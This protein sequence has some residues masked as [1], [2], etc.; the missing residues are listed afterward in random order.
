MCFEM[1][2][3]LGTSIGTC[4]GVHVVVDKELNSVYT[5]QPGRQEWVTVIECISATGQKIP[6]YVI[7]KGE[8][9]MTHW[10][11]TSPPP[12]WMFA[13]NHNGWTNNLHGLKWLYHFDQHTKLSL[14]TPDEYR[15][16][17][18]DG[19]D[20]H[21]SAA[22]VGYCL[23][24]RIALVL[25]PPHS[26][27]ILQPLDVGV[28]SPLKKALALRQSRLFRSGVRRIQKAEWLDHFIEA[29]ESSVSEANILSGWR[30]SGLFPE[31]LHRMLH[32]FPVSHRLDLASMTTPICLPQTLPPESTAM[33]FFLSSSPPPPATLRSTNQAF[34][35]SFE[36][37]S[38]DP[39]LQTHI[40]RLSGISERLQ[41]ENH[42]LSKELDEVKAIQAKRKER[43]SGKCLILKGKIVVSTEDI[44]KALEEAEKATSA[45][46]KASGQKSKKTC[47]GSK[48]ACLDNEDNAL[49]ILDDEIL[50]CI[51]V[52]FQS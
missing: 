42:I 38:I 37:S 32:Q 7:F 47:D 27:H 39:N 44:Q 13:V 20:S 6:P 21:I 49:E 51:E 45:K 28:F 4:Q 48:E 9:L 16:L 19:H 26:S 23:Q 22:F 36:N 3:S 2:I 52:Q 30:G 14:D 5:A 18:C 40:R 46:K 25:L 35:T 8:H 15:L 12:G 17:L 1:L 41:A 50:D 24:N 29:R 34:L 33:P 31:N 10:T 43:A 11:S